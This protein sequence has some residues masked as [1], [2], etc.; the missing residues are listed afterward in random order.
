MG[1]AGEQSCQ[2]APSWQE[3]VVCLL[4]RH[5]CIGFAPGERC[6]DA[7]LAA[8]RSASSCRSMRAP[9]YRCSQLADPAEHLHVC[10]RRW[11][12]VVDWFVPSS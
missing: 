2:G 1:S 6:V 11:A 12:A 3:R 7:C 8:D 5:T 10:L 9:A 4:H